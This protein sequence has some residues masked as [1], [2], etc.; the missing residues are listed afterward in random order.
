MRRTQFLILLPVLLALFGTSRTAAGSTLSVHPGC[1]NN[2]NFVVIC[3]P[4][5]AGGTGNYVS[6]YWQVT[7]TALGQPT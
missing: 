4:W 5:V 7:D 3:S 6:Y 2:G 1:F